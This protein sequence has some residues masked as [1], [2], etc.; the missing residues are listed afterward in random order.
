MHVG[1]YLGLLHASEQHLVDALLTVADHHRDEPDI[2][3]A[4]HLAASWSRDA[5]Q[6]LNPLV[7]R[8]AEEKNDEPD[9]L[10]QALFGGPRT[11]SLALLRDLHDLWL[12]VSEVQLCLIVLDQAAKALRDDE[13]EG[14]CS[15]WS[16]QTKRQLAWLQTRIKQ[17]APQALVVA[18]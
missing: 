1:N 4:C 14:F 9:R 18:A 5:I 2:F 6:A 3:Q 13:L 11:G 17:A 16:G 7:E 8:Y 15:H 10:S 12:L